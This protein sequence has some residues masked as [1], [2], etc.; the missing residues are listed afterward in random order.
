MRETFPT[1][2]ADSPIGARAFGNWAVGNPDFNCQDD[3]SNTDC[4]FD[5]CNIVAL[6]SNPDVANAYYTMESLNRFHTYFTGLSQAFE[7]SAIATA[8]SKDEWAETFYVDKDVKSIIA[9]RLVFAFLQIIIGIGAA[10]AGL[11]PAVGGAIASGIVAVF[12]GSTNAAIA[13]IATR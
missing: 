4:D 1:G 9:L 6:N 12:G 2:V 8:L 3:G 5:P 11:G 7:V 10:L 13:A